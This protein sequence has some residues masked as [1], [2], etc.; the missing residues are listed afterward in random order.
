MGDDWFGYRDAWHVTA[1]LL[2]RVHSVMIQLDSV[3]AGQELQVAHVNVVRL[4]SGTIVQV[5]ACVSSTLGT[6]R[7]LDK[8]LKIHIL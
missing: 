4:A 8:F 7:K 3:D 2:L 6:K 5:V 1:S